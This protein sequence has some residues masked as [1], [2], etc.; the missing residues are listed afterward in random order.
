MLI[1]LCALFVL[2]LTIY[3]KCAPSVSFI[4]HTVLYAKSFVGFSFPP[5][6]SFVQII[7]LQRKTDLYLHDLVVNTANVLM[8]IVVISAYSY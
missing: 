6:H 2:T 8:D 5:L 1:S 4:Q 3:H 7:S